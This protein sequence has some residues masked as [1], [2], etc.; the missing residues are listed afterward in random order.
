MD[1]LRK[2]LDVNKKKLEE[3]Q[4][5][6]NGLTSRLEHFVAVRHSNDLTIII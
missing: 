2:Q 3:T 6:V 4:I 1:L 5:N